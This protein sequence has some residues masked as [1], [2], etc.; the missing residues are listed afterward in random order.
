MQQ[1]RRLTLTLVR[2]VARTELLCCMLSHTK[3]ILIILINKINWKHNALL[4]NNF[5]NWYKTL[6]LRQLLII[7]YNC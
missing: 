4:P 1:E 7:N 5:A 6:D 3:T 2:V